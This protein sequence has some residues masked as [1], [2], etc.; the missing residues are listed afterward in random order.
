MT[1]KPVAKS[2]A[3]VK[4]PPAVEQPS[5]QQS[6]R[7]AVGQIYRQEYQTRDDPKVELNFER[8]LVWHKT[9]ASICGGLSLGITKRK[10]SRVDLKNWVEALD[11]LVKEMKLAQEVKR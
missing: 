10:F 3:K 2:K 1:K 8:I 5:D 7:K 11:N 6:S 4:K 9:L